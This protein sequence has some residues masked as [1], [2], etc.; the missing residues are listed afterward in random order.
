MEDLKLCIYC[1]K[2]CQVKEY[3]TEKNLCIDCFDLQ[4][5]FYLIGFF[6]ILK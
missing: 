5:K 6:L 4:V 3:K 1:D 2:F